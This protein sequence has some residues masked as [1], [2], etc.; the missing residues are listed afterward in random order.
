MGI[1]IAR[2]HFCAYPYCRVGDQSVFAKLFYLLRQRLNRT[3]ELA[4]PKRNQLNVLSGLRERARPPMFGRA[5]EAHVSVAVAAALAVV[6][7]APA[8]ADDATVRILTQNV[9]Q[10]TNFDEINAATSAPDFFAAVTTTYQN[11]LATNPVERAAAVAGEIVRERPDIVS[12]QEATILRTGPLGAGP[13]PSAANVQFDYLQSLMGDLNGQGQHYAIVATVPGLDAEA[14]A[15][16]AS[17]F[18]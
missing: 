6:C 11:V 17:T 14:P 10:G 4:M 9:Y 8:R 1:A 5:S 16:W 3:R 7:A 18:A 12:L 15:R 2:S 13:P